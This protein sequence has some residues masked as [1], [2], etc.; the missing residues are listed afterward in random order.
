MAINPNR[1]NR[2]KLIDVTPCPLR[3]HAWNMFEWDG[4]EKCAMGDAIDKMITAIKVDRRFL[5]SKEGK[6]E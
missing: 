4:L 3:E 6:E 1:C 2:C 5:N